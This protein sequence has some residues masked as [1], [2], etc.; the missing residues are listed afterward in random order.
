MMSP[1]Q[2]LTSALAALLAAS[3]LVNIGLGRAWLAARDDAA[4]AIGQRDTARA[5]ASACSDAT[6]DLRALADQR[7]IEAQAARAEA[8]AQARTHQ[9]KADAILATPPAVPGD[10]CRSAQLRVDNWLKGRAQP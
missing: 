2:I 9:Q 7:A 3:V 10:D 4:T 6:D 8:A 1:S 5:D